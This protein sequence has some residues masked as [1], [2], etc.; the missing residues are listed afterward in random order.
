MT[1]KQTKKNNKKSKLDTITQFAIPA[2]T[3]LGQIIIAFKNPKYG[4]L[5][6]LI[7]QPFWIYSSFTSMKKAGQVGIFITAIIY[8]FI[9][10]FGVINYWFF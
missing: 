6:I 4:L 10:T 1:K 5:L 8:T 3:I 9:T 2:L 7:S